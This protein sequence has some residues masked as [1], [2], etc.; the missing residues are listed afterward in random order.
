MRCW[1]QGKG[2]GLEA[3]GREL[4]CPEP[5]A[6]WC[7]IQGPEADC[8]LRGEVA[9][10]WEPDGDAGGRRPWGGGWGVVGRVTHMS[11]GFWNTGQRTAAPGEG[12]VGRPCPGR[13][14]SQ[15]SP[16]LGTE[17]DREGSPPRGLSE[18]GLWLPERGREKA[19]E[20]QAGGEDR[21]PPQLHPVQERPRGE[22]AG[23]QGC[24]GWPR[25]AEMLGLHFGVN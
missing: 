8:G 19:V 7:C 11:R 2:R 25:L 23:V 5:Q 20:G 3:R 9:M 17:R 21:R 1:P 13:Q 24:E 16:G 6:G 18:R 10:P 15:L 14:A 22:G 12:S 4:G